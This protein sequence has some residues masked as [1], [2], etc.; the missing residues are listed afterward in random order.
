MIPGTNFTLKKLQNIV[1]HHMII[2]S[3]MT[4][5]TFFLC[6]Y[7]SIPFETDEIANCMQEK[8]FANVKSVSELADNPNFQFLNDWEVVSAFFLTN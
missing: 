5:F 8:D 1:R 2:I 7:N 6:E 4:F 3:L